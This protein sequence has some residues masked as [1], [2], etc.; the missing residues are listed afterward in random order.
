MEFS[1]QEYWS[2]LLFPSPGD[3]PNPGTKP[4]YPTLQ[5]D[6]LQS[7]SPG[8]LQKLIQKSKEDI[9]MVQI[10]QKKDIKGNKETQN[11]KNRKM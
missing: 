5:A 11:R 8:K 3:L 10:I 7:E 9:K 2:G 1:R 4:R 6:S